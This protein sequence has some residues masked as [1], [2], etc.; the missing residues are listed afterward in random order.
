VKFIGD[1][2]NTMNAIFI[3]FKF[4]TNFLHHFWSS[5]NIALV[6]NARAMCTF[7]SSHIDQLKSIS[8]Q[9]KIQKEIESTTANP[10]N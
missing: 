9:L 1:Q 10:S 6:K 4:L 2:I 7:F 3:K 8:P 5:S